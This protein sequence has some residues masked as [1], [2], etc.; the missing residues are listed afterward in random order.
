MKKILNFAV[1]ATLAICGC[2]KSNEQIAEEIEFSP[3]ANE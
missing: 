2:S 1:M 3:N